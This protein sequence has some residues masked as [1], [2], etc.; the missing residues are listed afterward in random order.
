[1]KSKPRSAPVQAS[2]REE[3]EEQLAILC[4]GYNV[5]CTQH[6]KQAFFT[7][8]GKMTLPQWVRCVDLAVSEEGPEEL[9]TPKGIWR[10]HRGFRR[11]PAQSNVPQIEEQDH[12]LFF[13]NRL[14]FRHVMN[15]G[16]LGSMG[17]FVPGRGMTDSQPSAEL[18]D[19]RRVVRALVEWFLGPITEGAADATPHEF[20]SQMIMALAK[21]SPVD[22]VTL[23]GWRAVVSHE[24]AHKPF[25]AYMGRPLPE[26][27]RP[28]LLDLVAAA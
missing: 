6:R 22:Q 21:V 12:L 28:M 20:V 10:I 2:E 11:G 14:F 16:G 13:A 4:A 19:A 17:K 9:P 27:Y 3:F 25:E 7:G 8:L 23:D 24:D 26:K 5:P 1:M 18:I 15:R